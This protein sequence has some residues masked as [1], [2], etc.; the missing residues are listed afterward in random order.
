MPIKIELSADTPGELHRMIREL[1]DQLAQTT[2]AVRLSGVASADKNTITMHARVEAPPAVADETMPEDAEPELT[3]LD[4]EPDE[5]T[6]AK[7]R[8]RPK[9]ARNKPKLPEPTPVDVGPATG[10]GAL[11]PDDARKTAITILSSL[12]G[13]GAEAQD[14][15]RQLQRDY[16]VQKFAEL[17]ADKSFTLLTDA[18][19]I[20]NELT[21]PKATPATATA[22]AVGAAVDY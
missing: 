15:I 21:K 19:R 22:T 3:A 11:S 18:R 6:G 17:P 20:E 10:D 9:G 13:R 14:K 8:G 5:D 4:R 12:Y 7:G 16:G 2:P 1:T